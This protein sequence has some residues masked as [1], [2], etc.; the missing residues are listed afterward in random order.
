MRHTDARAAAKHTPH[1]GYRHRRAKTSGR[2]RAQPPPIHGELS[3]GLLGPPGVW[4]KGL[5]VKRR[6]FLFGATALGVSAP[7]MFKA[8]I[9]PLEAQE[10]APAGAK[11]AKVAIFPAIGFSRVG[12][13]SEWFTAPEVPGLLNE[14]KGGFKDSEGR[15]K[16]QVQRFRVYGYDAQG[17]VVREL[18]A[19]DK[20][21]WTVHVANTKAAWY[22]FV[23]AMD[24]GEA[25]PGVPGALRNPAI[26]H[27]KR[28]DMLVIDPGPVTISGASVNTAGDDAAYR[29]QGR[30]WQKLDV[31]L[32]HLR[33][34]E[35]GRL[36]VF[37]AN[38]VSRT[39]IEQNPVRDFTNNDGWH[40]D[41][42]DG[43]VKATVTIDGA[44]VECEPAWVV[45]C[46]PKFAPQLEPIVTLY[47]AA[48]EAMVPLGH[49]KPPGSKVS[50][51]R[52]VLPILRRAGSM[53][54][55]AA[56]SFLG[57]AW[58]DVGDLS[59]PAVIA[60]LDKP[61]AKDK[62]ARQKVLAA[63]RR[64]GGEDQR[65]DALP[66]ML[67][68]GVNYPDSPHAWLTLT[69]IQ[70]R[71]LEL[72]ADG[73]FEADNDDKEADAIAS[74]DDLP[75]ALQ[76]EALTR[77]ALDACSGGAFHPGV[78]ITWPI[79]HPALYRDSKQT[80]LPFR[81]AISERPSLVQDLGRQ[82]NPVNVFAGNPVK[83]KEGAPI[84][85]Q[86]PGDLTRWMGVP[87]QGDAF[88]CQ[89]VQT[90]DGFPTPIWWPALLP[91]DV[92]PEAFYEQM[93]R[94]DLSNEERLRF[95][96]S[97][98]PWARG[99][100]GIGLHVEAGYTDGL[101]RMIELWTR[102]GVVVRRPGPKGLPGVPEQVYVEVQRGSMDIT[103]PR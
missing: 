22:G 58:T 40:D 79:R 32:G 51:R 90:A 73:K 14:P 92:L 59:D 15:V 27:D 103:A 80:S 4:K 70:Y 85:P 2:A 68:D 57:A 54:W 39:A 43:W 20:V 46:G 21:R 3:H 95:Y 34:D 53:Q 28:A 42:C 38:G 96:H 30:F 31:P 66:P 47:D 8:A 87:W 60:T 64:P 13:S 37:A 83:P 99:A 19:A 91:V 77:A 72:W 65:A 10:A 6:D 98:V 93:M 74:L 81:I 24:R 61:T 62:P 75:V 49:L 55:V 17:R 41:W 36:L 29:M 25:A 82:L 69:P 9:S 88:S 78:E 67:G 45:C 50:F 100:A 76:P 16:K 33:T 23:N 35:K 84:G 71:I 44:E 7:F 5:T 1:L 101:R 86:A 48:R 26:P 56:A 63:F 97:R 52:D 102:M 12:N 18:G 11:I 89:A 94:T